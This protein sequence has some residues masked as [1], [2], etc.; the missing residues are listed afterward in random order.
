VRQYVCVCMCVRVCVRVCARMHAY[1]RV[2]VCARV[3]LCVSRE[4]V[5]DLYPLSLFV[6]MAYL[7]TR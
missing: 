6:C 5:R 2:C 7:D 3:C 4:H 1:A